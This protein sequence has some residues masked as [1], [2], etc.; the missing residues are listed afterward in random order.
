MRTLLQRF[1]EDQAGATVIEYGLIAAVLSVAILAGGGQAF[2]ALKSLF[3]DR[4]A[5]ALP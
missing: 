4:L 1:L 3:G 5:N 2:D